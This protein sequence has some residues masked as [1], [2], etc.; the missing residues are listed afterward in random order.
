MPA[1]AVIPAP[2]AYVNFAAVKKLVV[3]PHLKTQKKLFFFYI[4]LRLKYV[5][6]TSLNSFYGT[7]YGNR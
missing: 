6:I 3:G 1:A 4:E 2:I 7:L 5:T